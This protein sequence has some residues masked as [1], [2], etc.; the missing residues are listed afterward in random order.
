MYFYDEKGKL[1]WE[2]DCVSGLATADRSTP[3]GVYS[4]NLKQSPSTLVGYKNGKKDYETKVSY[5]M[6]FVG[7]SVGLHD[8]NWRSSFGGT[9]YKSNGSHGC[10]NLPVKKAKK[11]YSLIEVGDVVSVHY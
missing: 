1:I 7:N 4:I 3:T 9:I 8:A 5:W 10:I 11:L 6:P 2:S